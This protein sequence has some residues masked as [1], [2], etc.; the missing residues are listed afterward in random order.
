MII[1]K[2]M[3]RI[4]KPNC[5]ILIQFQMSLGCTNN[6][7]AKVTPR[8]LVYNGLKKG[9]ANAKISSSEMSAS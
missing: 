2:N 5:I 3:I 4:N 8:K 6:L 7:H 9:Y 1:D